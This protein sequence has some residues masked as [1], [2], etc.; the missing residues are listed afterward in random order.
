LEGEKAAVK[1]GIFFCKSMIKEGVALFKSVLDGS[2]ADLDIDDNEDDD[3]EMDES[4]IE[5]EVEEDLE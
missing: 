5:S 4:D 3:Q 2:F 1:S